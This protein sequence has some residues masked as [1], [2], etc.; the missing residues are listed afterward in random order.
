MGLRAIAREN[1][2]SIPVSFWGKIK[3]MGLMIFLA[4]VILNPYQAEGFSHSW[5]LIEFILLCIALLL[6][7]FSAKTY[8]D[9]FKKEYGPLDS[10][11]GQSKKVESESVDWFKDQSSEQ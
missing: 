2:F 11:F 9:A 6:T 7:V 8:Y 1:N 5:N 4:F 10:L 3:T